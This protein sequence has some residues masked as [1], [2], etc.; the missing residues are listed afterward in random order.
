M[1][2]SAADR[3]DSIRLGASA[4]LYMFHSASAREKLPSCLMETGIRTNVRGALER[5]VR[6]P[7][8]SVDV[9]V[10][11]GRSFQTETLIIEAMTKRI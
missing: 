7:W 2:K 10:I 5:H 4:Y 1:D 8:H 3:G 6:R 9:E 11:W